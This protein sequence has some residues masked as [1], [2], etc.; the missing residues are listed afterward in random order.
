MLKQIKTKVLVL[1]MVLMASITPYT[2]AAN[3]YWHDDINYPKIDT[4]QF[5][6]TYVDL[7]SVK[8][9]MIYNGEDKVIYSASYKTI[10]VDFPTDKVYSNDDE[11]EMI[12]F[13]IEKNKETG[14]TQYLQ[15]ISGKLRD[16]SKTIGGNLECYYIA[17]IEIDSY[18]MLNDEI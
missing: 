16:L 14:Y 9:N 17:A 4:Y 7:N 15:V 1:V 2:N 11:D 5:T 13:I 10:R 18:L 3:F 8:V 6:H 12:D